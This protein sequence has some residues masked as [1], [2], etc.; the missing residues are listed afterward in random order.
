LLDRRWEGERFFTEGQQALEFPT[1][2]TVHSYSQL[3][4]SL[5]SQQWKPNT[6]T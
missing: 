3:L 6:V 2:A 4:G 5:E 1:M